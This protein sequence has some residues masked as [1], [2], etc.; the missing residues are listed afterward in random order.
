MSWSCFSFK[1]DDDL[2]QEPPSY[3]THLVDEKVDLNLA[4]KKLE[5][6]QYILLQEKQELSDSFTALCMEH[7]KLLERVEKIENKA[8]A[9]FEIDRWT[10]PANCVCSVMGGSEPITHLDCDC[11]G[12][13]LIRKQYPTFDP[14][15]HSY[16]PETRPSGNGI[17]PLDSECTCLNREHRQKYF[18]TIELGII[19]GRDLELSKT[20]IELMQEYRIAGMEY[21]KHRKSYYIVVMTN[22]CEYGCTVVQNCTRKDGIDIFQY[23]GIGGIIYDATI[24]DLFTYDKKTRQYKKFI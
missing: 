20:Q 14:T 24:D 8:I 21:A 2:S 3:D 18:H 5:E 15:S 11:F 16:I 1:K 23:K 13:L 6:K 10:N 7:T 19:K 22:R 12:C 9:C 4:I 17:C